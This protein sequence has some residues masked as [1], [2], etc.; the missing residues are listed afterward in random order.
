MVEECLNGKSHYRI[1]RMVNKSG[2]CLT[3]I[4]NNKYNVE[5]IKYVWQKS[6]PIENP[7]YVGIHLI[8]NQSIDYYA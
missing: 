8:D 4:N 3:D 7:D 5:K 6:V 2:T 1:V